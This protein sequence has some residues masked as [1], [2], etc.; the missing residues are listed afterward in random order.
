MKY[1]AF[2]MIAFVD[3]LLLI[4]RQFMPLHIMIIILGVEKA[5]NCIITLEV[6][7]VI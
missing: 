2:Q 3:L 5:K 4:I 6:V 7:E 1:L